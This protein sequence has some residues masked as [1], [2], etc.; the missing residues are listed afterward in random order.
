[1]I[2]AARGSSRSRVFSKTAHL[3]DAGPACRVYGSMAV[4]KVTGNLH[5]VSP[6]FVG[7]KKY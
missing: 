3:V 2:R 6:L 1:M 5:I 4:K 7:E